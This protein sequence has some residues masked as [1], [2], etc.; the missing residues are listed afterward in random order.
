MNSKVEHTPGPWFHTDPREPG[1][2]FI[3]RDDG[4][5]RE[6]GEYLAEIYSDEEHG[7][8]VSDN[9]QYANAALIAACP[10]LLS[11]CVAAL[12]A[13]NTAPRF[14]VGTTTSYRIASQV[15]AAIAKARGQK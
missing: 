8:D 15:E 11:A 1:S 14:N 7:C 5:G 13:L 9:E 10:D 6:P 2:V 12:E 3:Y 4:K